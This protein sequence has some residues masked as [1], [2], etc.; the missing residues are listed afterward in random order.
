MII[1]AYIG[2]AYGVYQDSGES[3]TGCAIL[4]RETGSVL[5]SSLVQKPS[6][7]ICLTLPVELFISGTRSSTSDLHW[8]T[9][10]TWAAWRW[11]SKEDR[12]LFT[13]HQ[14]SSLLAKWE[15]GTVGNSNTGALK[16]CLPTSWQSLCKME[17]S[18]DVLAPTI[19]MN[20]NGVSKGSV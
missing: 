15:S 6:L 16:T 13:A 20:G 5:S 8:C 9:K 2:A 12:D 14:H 3:H 1:K 11:I 17:T 19:V 18:R 4:L 10:T 7:W